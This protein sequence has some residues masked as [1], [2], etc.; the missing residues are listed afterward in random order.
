[1]NNIRL[2]LGKGGV[3][4]RWTARLLSVV[5]SSEFLLILFLAL[6]N[7]DKPQGAAIPGLVLLVLTI[8]GCFAAWRWEKIGGVVVVIGA[9]CLSVEA[10][11]ASLTFGLGSASFLPALVYSAPFLVVGILFWIC[12]IQQ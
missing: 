2:T 11:L 3:F 9:L 4:V 12:G 8:V 7:E 1:M 5:V 10:Y 6:T